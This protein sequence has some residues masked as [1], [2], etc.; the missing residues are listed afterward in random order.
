MLTLNGCSSLLA[1]GSSA[2]A[3][4]AGSALADA[5][6]SNAFAVT[7]IGL[8]VQAGTRA[9]VQYGQRK[10]RNETQ[11]QIASTAGPLAPGQVANWKVFHDIALEPDDSGRVTV[12][13]TISTGAL[14]CKEIVF[15]VDKTNQQGSMPNVPNNFYVASICRNGDQWAWAS[16]E[17]ATARW[18]SLQ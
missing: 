18:G 2:G 15:S 17:P 10:V 6:T 5:V 16:A 9:A 14:E 1:E 7:G 4:I 3:G 8:G 13:R 12:S 11:Q